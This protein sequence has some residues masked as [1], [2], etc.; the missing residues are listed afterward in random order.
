M[1]SLVALTLAAALTGCAAPKI[2][3]DYNPQSTLELN[4]AINVGKFD[5]KRREGIEEN[6]IP[7][8]ALGSGLQTAQPISEFFEDAMRKEFRKSGLSLD[9]KKCLMQGSIEKLLID[10]LGFTVDF[11]VDVDYR[12]VNEQGKNIF[13]QRIDTNLS[14]MSKFTVAQVMLNNLNK[15][16]SDNILKLMKSTEFKQVVDNDCVKK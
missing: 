1:R 11:I 9:T 16:F 8:T 4:G 3:L 15:M 10:D 13:K 6:Q 14:G 12:I 7:N 5:Y 2:T